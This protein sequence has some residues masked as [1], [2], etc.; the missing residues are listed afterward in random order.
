MAYEFDIDK[1]QDF[2]E[3]LCTSN[4]DVAHNVNGNKSFARFESDA[5]INEIKKAAGKN[6]VVVADINGR[7]V[8]D[9]DD[10]KLRR[11]VV[12]R[13]AVYAVNNTEDAKKAAEKLSEEIMFDFMTR[14]EKQQEDDLDENIPCGVMH[15]L[16]P[17]NFSWEK[18]TDQP[19][20][21][22]HYGWDLTVP[23]DV[24]MPAYNPAKWNP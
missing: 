8:G 4:T 19:W 22:N 10:R 18:I 9:K 14:M 15:F 11:E 5:Q 7:R 2:I 17:E 16:K 13:F 24:W 20:L 3:A 21:L 12:L 1:I 6:I 23:F